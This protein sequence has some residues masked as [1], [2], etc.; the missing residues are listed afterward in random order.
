MVRDN[1]EAETEMERRR[2]RRKAEKLRGL[3]RRRRRLV[4]A[5]L[6]VLFL[7]II[8]AR[9]YFDKVS[10]GATI[11]VMLAACLAEGRTVLENVFWSE[12]GY[13]EK[14]RY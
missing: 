7:P 13:I 11:N 14:Q 6:A 5:I 2:R 4:L 10:V 1:R 8:G 9:I 3:K 12:S